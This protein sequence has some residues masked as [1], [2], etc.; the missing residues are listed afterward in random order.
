[1]H[2][3]RAIVMKHTTLV[4]PHLPPP[5]HLPPHT[6]CDD[7]DHPLV[8]QLSLQLLKCSRDGMPAPTA[9]LIQA[10]REL[11]VRPDPVRRKRDGGY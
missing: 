11:Q 6:P 3:R 7:V 8:E 2:L 9:A 4:A 10:D 1:M 5:T